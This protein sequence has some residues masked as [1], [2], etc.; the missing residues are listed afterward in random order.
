MVDHV[1]DIETKMSI[2]MDFQ[3]AESEAAKGATEFFRQRMKEH[4]KDERLLQGIA[5]SVYRNF[6]CSRS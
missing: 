1:K 3:H 2:A 5:A 6:L 4:I